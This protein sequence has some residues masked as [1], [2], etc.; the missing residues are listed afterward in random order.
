MTGK[1]RTK[2]TGLYEGPYKIAKQT[3]ADITVSAEGPE[4][5]VVVGRFPI[6]KVMD[7]EAQATAYAA[8]PE[9]IQ[10]LKDVVSYGPTTFL[11]ARAVG[12]LMDAGIE[13]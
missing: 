4:G 13:P 10:L 11:A 8:L 6:T 3:I 5:P 1:R 7:A 9:M 12:I 2:H